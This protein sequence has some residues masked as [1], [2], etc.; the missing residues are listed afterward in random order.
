MFRLGI[1]LIDRARAGTRKSARTASLEVLAA[2]FADTSGD[3]AERI[4]LA[5]SAAVADAIAANR[6][7]S[8]VTYSA[9]I[10]LRVE[11]ERAGYGA[12]Y[13]FFP[14]SEGAARAANGTVTSGTFATAKGRLAALAKDGFD[15]VYLPHPPD[16]H[17]QPK[18]PE[19]H[20]HCERH[21]PR[22]AVGD[23]LGGGRP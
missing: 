19:Q 7:E 21:R 8:L 10:P 17:D 15:V 12:W 18:R 9:N 6:P 2:A 22:V 11:R 16:R 1:D 4:A 13:E 3:P 5:H 23:W 20:P 14:R